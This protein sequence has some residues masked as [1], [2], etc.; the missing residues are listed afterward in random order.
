MKKVTRV[1]TKKEVNEVTTTSNVYSD[2]IKNTDYSVSSK[3]IAAIKNISFKFSAVRSAILSYVANETTIKQF[4]KNELIKLLRASKKDRDLF[5]T[6][7]DLSAISFKRIVKKDANKVDQVAYFRAYTVKSVLNACDFY[8]RNNADLDV[9][10]IASIKNE[11]EI[12]AIDK[13]KKQI[14]NLQDQVHVLAS[15][16]EQLE[17]AKTE[18]AE[19]LKEYAEQLAKTE[20]TLQNKTAL[21]EY[22][23]IKSNRLNIK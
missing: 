9:S 15:T 2:K 10:F 11:H 7:C 22:V 21:Y 3:I 17:T 14:A 1:N 18:N 5:L 6:L 19:L 16:I 20:K 8:L 23:K 4:D 12:Q 13:L